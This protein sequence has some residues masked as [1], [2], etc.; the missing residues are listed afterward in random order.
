MSSGTSQYLLIYIYIYIRCV[1]KYLEWNKIHPKILMNETLIFFIIVLVWDLTY[2]FSRVFNWSK[3]SCNLSFYVIYRYTIFISSM[4]LYLT[5]EMN[6]CSCRHCWSKGINSL[7]D[8][9]SEPVNPSTV[10]LCP[11]I[12]ELRSVYVYVHIFWPCYFLKVFS[13]SFFFLFFFFFFF[14][15]HTVLSNTSNS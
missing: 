10:I 2:L 12:R 3:H 1:H 11:K 5:L 14:F 8:W 4:C 7:I 15:L 13:F 9:F 6:L